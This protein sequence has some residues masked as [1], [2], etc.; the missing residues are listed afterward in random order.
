MIENM[1]LNVQFS[2]PWVQK[3]FRPLWNADDWLQEYHKNFSFL[4]KL[5]AKSHVHQ[6]VLWE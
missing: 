5:I 4:W 1:T 2:L 6:S 3:T